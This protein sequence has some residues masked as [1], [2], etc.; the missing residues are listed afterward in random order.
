MSF[1]SD[2][3]EYVKT[4]SN[5]T[6]LVSTKIYP[7]LAP[8]STALPYITYEI[9]SRT[10]TR[11]MTGVSAFTEHSVQFDALANTE[12]EVNMISDALRN[13]LD[14]F[15]ATMGQTDIRYVRFENEVDN[16]SIES[17]AGN[18]AKIH[19]RTLDY[20][21]GYVEAIPTG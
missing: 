2:L 8:T 12:G 11:H 14:G 5:V 21:F 15:Q 16:T 9:S 4:S 19:R 7:G 17:Q 20:V 3:Y 13:I 1:L 18:Q 10:P 6:A